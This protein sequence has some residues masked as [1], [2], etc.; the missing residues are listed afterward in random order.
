MSNVDEGNAI[1]DRWH[2]ARAAHKAAPD[3]K[4]DAAMAARYAAENAALGH[5]GFGK[6]I[7]AYNAR[8]PDDPI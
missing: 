4:K 5:F 6:H 1:L 7:E 8:F 3:D 2:A